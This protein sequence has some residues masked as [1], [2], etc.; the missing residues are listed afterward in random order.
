MSASPKLADELCDREVDDAHGGQFEREGDAVETATDLGDRG[1][2]GGIEHEARRRVLRSLDEQLDGFETSQ[3]VGRVVISRKLER[4]HPPG[5][6]TGMAERLA[7]RGQDDEIGAPR[8][9]LGG[10]RH[11]GVED[12]LAVVEN[13]Q[14]RAARELVDE[15]RDPRPVAL[16]GEVESAADRRRDAVTVRHACQLH[17]PHPVRPARARHLTVRQLDGQAGLACAAGAGERE[18]ARPVEHPAQ[19]G[20]F[21]MTTDEARR[22]RGQVVRTRPRIGGATDEEPPVDGGRLRLGRD[23]VRLGEPVP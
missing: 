19:L 11:D 16:E 22:Q 23:A 8:Q 20:Q 7:A 1:S 21:T 9:E 13:E 15:R 6:L 14:D 5:D 17:E 2:G 12:V 4:G 10:Q 3:T 18:Q